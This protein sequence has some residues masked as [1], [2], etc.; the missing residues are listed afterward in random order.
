MQVTVSPP[1][2]PIAPGQARV[3]QTQSIEGLIAQRSELER[4]LSQLNDRRRDLQRQR[5]NAGAAEA[6]S[7]EGRIAALDGRTVKIEDQLAQV[8]E[9]VATAIAAN[10][11]AGSYGFGA[12]PGTSIDGQI[13]RDIENA[14]QDAVAQGM[15]IGASS[16]LG[17]Y[18]LWRG[19]RRFV[20]RRKPKPA[21]VIPDHTVQ[22]QQLQHSMDSIA[23]EVERI[24]EAQRFS[25]KLLKEK[26]RAE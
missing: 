5:S 9:Q 17:I 12:F 7:V 2:A 18:V 11:Q 22:I 25:A 8:N 3:A 10:P 24:S 1:T 15:M 4:Q 13:R 23:I 26:V 19:F 16:I 6:R 20:L 21:P 14:V